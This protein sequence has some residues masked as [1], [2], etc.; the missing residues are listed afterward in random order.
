[1][2]ADGV[3]RTTQLSEPLSYSADLVAN[4]AKN[5]GLPILPRCCDEIANHRPSDG[6]HYADHDKFR[7]PLVGLR[8]C[9]Y[10][11]LGGVV[12]RKKGLSTATNSV[13]S[14]GAKTP[15]IPSWEILSNGGS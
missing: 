8:D 7:R 3:E 15:S 12:P 5:I 10:R 1:M 11:V 6:K 14:V 13:T 4:L 2:A 9:S